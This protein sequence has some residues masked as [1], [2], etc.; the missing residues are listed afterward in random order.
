MAILAPPELIT[1]IDAHLA[2]TKQTPSAFGRLVNNDPNLVLEIRRGR[3]PRRRLANRI[4]EIIGEKAQ[5]NGHAD[6]AH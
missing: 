2:A 4:L 6:P 5:K 3:I 1:I